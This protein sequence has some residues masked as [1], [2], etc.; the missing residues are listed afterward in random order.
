MMRL[1]MGPLAILVGAVLPVVA[2]SSSTTQPE[3]E[4]R[5]LNERLELRLAQDIAA[6]RA[7][8]E[9][10]PEGARVTVSDRHLFPGDGTELDDKSRYTLA[11]VVQGLLALRIVKIELADSQS[12]SFGLQ[13]TR[14]QAV[15]KF[16][17]NYGLGPVLAPAMPQ[18]ASTGSPMQGFTI[19]ISIIANRPVMIVPDEIALGRTPIWSSTM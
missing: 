1:R 5:L 8:L 9:P 7:T 2:C 18:L 19:T 14:T 15:A 13:A 6:N 10:L 3:R 11:S 4:A 16:F 12:A 17:Q